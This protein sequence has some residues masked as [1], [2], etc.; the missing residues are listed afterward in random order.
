MQIRRML[1]VA[2][3]VVT[4]L[5]R[6]PSPPA[7]HTTEAGDGPIRL[8][9]TDLTTDGALRGYA[10]FDSWK[11]AVA[12]GAGNHEAPEGYVPKLFGHGRLA[13]TVDQGQ[14]TEPGHRAPSTM[15]VCPVM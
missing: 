8:L 7:A 4:R 13:F 2:A 5:G 12:L 15:M 3:F 11:L 14:H 9:V 10:Q 6:E 1:V